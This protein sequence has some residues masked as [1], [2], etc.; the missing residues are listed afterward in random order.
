M[1]LKVLIVAMVREYPGLGA[2]IQVPSEKET[3]ED[4][5]GSLFVDRQKLRAVSNSLWAYPA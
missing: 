3:Y 4:V 5:W 1:D 2:A